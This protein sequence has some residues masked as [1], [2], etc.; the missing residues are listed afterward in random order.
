M[1]LKRG[2]QF[3]PDDKNLWL[4]L[5]Q[6]LFEMCN[7][8]AAKKICKLQGL[9]NNISNTEQLFNRQFLSLSNEQSDS[10]CKERRDWPYVGRIETAKYGPLWPDL[11]LEPIKDGD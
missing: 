11:L 3:N 5:E 1:I 7:F 4:A 2:L 10:L 6:A 9:N 8:S